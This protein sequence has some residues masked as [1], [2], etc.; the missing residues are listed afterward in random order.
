[1]HMAKIITRIL[2]AVVILGGIFS[3]GL[4]PTSWFDRLPAF[5]Q[6]VLVVCA[7]IF[8]LFILIGYVFDSG[9][10]QKMFKKKSS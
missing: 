1:M 5:C 9:I 8:S 6:V 10:P 7:V 4:I 2:L 3:W